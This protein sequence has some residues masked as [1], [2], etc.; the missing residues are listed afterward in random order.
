M[1]FEGVLQRTRWENQWLRLENYRVSNAE[2]TLEII[3]DIP[4]PSLAGKTL[5]PEKLGNLFGVT[6]P[7]PDPGSRPTLA[8]ECLSG[9]PP[10]SSSLS[11]PGTLS[12]QPEVTVLST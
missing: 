4:I 7:G 2:K 11:I 3:V 9:S 6:Q 8:P 10:A 12:F 1:D 5:N